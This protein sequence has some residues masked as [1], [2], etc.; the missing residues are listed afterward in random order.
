MNGFVN[1]KALLELGLLEI[2]KQIYFWPFTNATL[3]VDRAHPPP[4]DQKENDHFQVKN[5]VIDETF[6]CRFE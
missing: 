2:G 4:I 5:A 3:I 1:Y 6:V